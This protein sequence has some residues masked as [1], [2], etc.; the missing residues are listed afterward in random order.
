MG[1]DPSG[2][3]EPIGQIGNTAVVPS[4]PNDI[5]K[6]LQIEMANGSV[7]HSHGDG[8]Y[9]AIRRDGSIARNLRGPKSSAMLRQEVQNSNAE[10][11]VASGFLAVTPP[12]E[13]IPEPVRNRIEAIPRLA[14]GT[15]EIIGG[16]GGEA[17]PTGVTQ[18]AGAVVIVHGADNVSTALMVLWDGQNH[19]T[20]TTQVIELGAYNAGLSADTAHNIGVGG[21]LVI[22]LGGSVAGYSKL[23]T[24]GRAP[25]SG[26]VRPGGLGYPGSMATAPA[27][28]VPSN[29]TVYS[30]AFEM[31]LNLADFGKSRTVHFN[32]AN[33]ALSDAMSA[34]AQFASQIEQ[35][36]PGA[37][38]AVSRTGGRQTPSGWTWEHASTTTANGREGVMRLVPSE[39][40][41]PGSPWWRVLHPDPGAAGGYSQWAIPRGAPKN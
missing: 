6:A 7:I 37:G 23:S 17:L 28:A 33:A 27:N 36:I 3:T 22:G 39:Q 10:A 30:T 11:S 14:G 4:M 31:Q 20:M 26:A 35:L 41:T 2:L 29:P 18:I 16:L 40:H 24:V 13:L 1:T 21:D 5:P 12:V 34:D 38:S 32:R 9:T 8:S 15:V 25:S 19:D